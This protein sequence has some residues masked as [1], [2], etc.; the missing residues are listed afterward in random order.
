[1]SAGH[2]SADHVEYGLNAQALDRLMDLSQVRK[3]LFEYRRLNR[4]HDLPYLAGYSKDGRT[5]YIDR[6]LP[7]E[8]TLE[9]DGQHR[10]IN[11]A[12]YLE[13]HETFEKTLIDELGYGYFPAHN[14]AT[15]AERREVLRGVGPGWWVPY[16]NEMNKYVKADGH[17][18]LVSVPPD[19]DMLPYVT[20][21]VDHALI[22][23]MQKAMG[24][25]RKHSKADVVYSDNRGKPDRHCGPVNAAGWDHAGC[26]YYDS[27]NACDIVRGWIAVRGGC[28][29]YEPYGSS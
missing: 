28:D 13:V 24:K 23:R 3:G 25:E 26:R 29:L 2:S 22:T 8:L 1:M 17:E 18:K 16:Q 5:I 14:A 15:G 4:E 21:P 7:E 10:V 6:H 19:L 20:A 9:L 11:S 27:P 12:H